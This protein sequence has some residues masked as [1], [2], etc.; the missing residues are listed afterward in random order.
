VDRAD[1][2][3][4]LCVADEGPGLAEDDAARI[5]DRFFRAGGGAGSGLGMAIVQ[6]VVHAH[7]GEVS[8][9]TAPGKGLAVTVTLPA[10]APDA[11]PTGV[12]EA[13]QAEVPDARSPLAQ[14]PMPASTRAGSP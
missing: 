2:V 6:G 12:P 7:G 9:R 14:V 4:R 11:G 1:G 8:V 13:R 5:F 3:V 10:G